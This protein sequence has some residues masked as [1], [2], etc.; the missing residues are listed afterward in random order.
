MCVVWKEGLLYVFSCCFRFLFGWEKIYLMVYYN[1]ILL[2]QICEGLRGEGTGG[3][4]VIFWVLLGSVGWGWFVR[5]GV[6]GRLLWR[7]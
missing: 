1:C 5:I 4:E 2:G 6:I 3:C 7:F